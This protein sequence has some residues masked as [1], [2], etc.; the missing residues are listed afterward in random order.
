M[1]RPGELRERVTVQIATGATNTLGE[2]VMTWNDSTAVWASVQGVGSR[3]LLTFGQTNVEVS[4]RVR[5]RY[6]SGLTQNMRIAW[7]GRT[8]EIISLLEHENR[9]EHEVICQEN[10]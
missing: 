3:E 9:S 5:M 6:L 7:R 10:L 8:L 2:T 4:H 1:I